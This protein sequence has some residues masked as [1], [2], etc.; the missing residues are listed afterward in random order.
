MIDYEN[1]SSTAMGGKSKGSIY[2]RGIKSPNKGVESYKFVLEK[3]VDFCELDSQ[4]IV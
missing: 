2:L 1:N 4:I 3:S